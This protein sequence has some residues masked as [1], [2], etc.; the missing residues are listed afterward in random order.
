MPPV[1]RNDQK[2]RRYTDE[3]IEWIRMIQ[4][5]PKRTRLSWNVYLDI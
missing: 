4:C 5:M 3:D 2:Y 1:K